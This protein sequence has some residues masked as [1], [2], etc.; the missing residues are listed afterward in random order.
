MIFIN[1]PKFSIVFQ[2]EDN[3]GIVVFTSTLCLALD[4]EQVGQ[5]R[6]S[7][8]VKLDKKKSRG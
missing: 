7:S 1:S 2:T 3:D 5:A 6:R 8:V 4:C